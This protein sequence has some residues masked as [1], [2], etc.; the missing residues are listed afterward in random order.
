MK[1]FNI[2]KKIS[3]VTNI[4]IL[5][6]IGLLFSLIMSGLG[7][8]FMKDINDSST[9]INRNVVDPLVKANNLRSDFYKLRFAVLQT[10]SE[11]DA[12]NYDEIDKLYNT[13]LASEAD[14]FTNREENEFDR[15]KKMQIDQLLR[16]YFEN[17]VTIRDTYLKANNPVL[18]DV[19][20]TF[21]EYAIKLD[22]N[23]NDLILYLTTNGDKLDSDATEKYENA[24]S[25]YAI[26]MG[27]V[28]FI[29]VLVSY[30][31]STSI[32]NSAKEMIQY[33]EEFG[34]GNLTIKIEEAD[35][36]EFGRMRGALANAVVNT[37]AMID[38]VQRKSDDLTKASHNLSA[39]SEQLS[40]AFEIVTQSVH[41]TSTGVGEQTRD[42]VTIAE[43]MAEF[44]E[45][46]T[47]IVQSI[48]VVDGLTRDI[49]DVARESDIHMNKAAQS[50]E[51]TN[52]VFLGLIRN[53]T[54]VNENVNKIDE[55]TGLINT[56]ADQ[57]NL[58]ALNAAIESA[59][60]GEHGK[61]FAVV[62]NEV[63]KLAEQSRIFS[64]RIS[65]QIGTISKD[66][67]HMLQTAD[68]M[69]MEMYT[70]KNDIANAL[71]SFANITKAV[72]DI[73]PKIH[74]LSQSAGHILQEKETISARV[75]NS[76][77]VAEEIFAKTEEIAST[78]EQT[79]ASSQEVATTA[80]VMSE[81]TNDMQAVMNNF[82][83]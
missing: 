73:G 50:V 27:S 19:K 51:H 64:Q 7:M 36:T 28:I 61:G 10:I 75:E 37:S 69:Q 42:L 22:N 82:K 78:S 40:A 65:D 80:E 48:Q 83:V 16:S 43:T 39:I 81:M 63:R 18:Q 79:T 59:R 1:V 8:Y 41:E 58:L 70:Q 76:T 38:T 9:L 5:V 62:A 44:G 11:Y 3:L 66:S 45:Q 68:E 74:H 24:W 57:T 46:L 77:A 54:K 71:H 14:Y 17:W 12:K 15:E 30:I 56:I 23:I 21:A 52:E 55:F 2:C 53:I 25:Y 33:C 4:R 13:V 67:E 47:E 29:V 60:A 20:Q 35:N 72:E 26:L 31:L 49:Q 6:A 32:N 34:K